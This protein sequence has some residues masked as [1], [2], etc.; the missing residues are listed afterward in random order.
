MDMSITHVQWADLLVRPRAGVSVR[1][2][3]RARHPLPLV[4][5]RG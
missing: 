3:P 4:G 2:R 1:V 5:R